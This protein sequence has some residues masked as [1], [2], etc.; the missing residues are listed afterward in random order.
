M[1]DRD[2]RPTILKTTGPEGTPGEAARIRLARTG[3]GRPVVVP[4]NKPEGST[5]GHQSLQLITA[6]HRLTQNP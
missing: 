5:T 4:G 1:P 3:S 2:L 6:A